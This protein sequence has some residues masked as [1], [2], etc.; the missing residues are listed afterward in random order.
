MTS[1]DTVCLVYLISLSLIMPA[2][3]WA[4]SVSGAQPGTQR[5]PYAPYVKAIAWIISAPW[6]L[7]LAVILSVVGLFPLVFNGAEYVYEHSPSPIQKILKALGVV[8]L[9][10]ALAG[11]YLLMLFLS[12]IGLVIVIFLIFSAS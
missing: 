3:M 11:T 1:C 9:S 12:P 8:A 6:L 10:P 7:V 5:K 4:E 2:F